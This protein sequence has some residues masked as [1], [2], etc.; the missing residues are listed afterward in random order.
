MSLELL[1]KCAA[2]GSALTLVLATLGCAGAK[3][4]AASSAPGS[5]PAGNPKAVRVE[6]NPFLGQE[7]FVAPY[8]NADQARRRL[9]N[10]DPA[11]AALVAKIADTPQARWLGSW[12]Q[13]VEVVAQNYVKAASKRNKLALIIAYNIPNRDCGQYSRGG[14]ADPQAYLKWV[15]ELAQGIGDSRAVV[16]LEPDALPQLD[17]CLSEADQAQRL[18]LL[19]SAVDILQAKPG[20]AVYLDAGHSAWVPAQVMAERLKRAGVEK[21]RGFAL[22]TSNYRLDAEL[23]TYGDALVSK[24]GD[25]HFII[26]SSRNGNGAAAGDNWCNP[27]GRALGRRPT[28]ETGNPHLDAF[29]WLK[30]PGESDGECGGGPAAGQWF[31]ERAFEMARN[32]KW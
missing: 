28:T 15:Q 20:V 24:L 21:A 12:T 13:N 5:E 3:Q 29:M 1:C 8:S 7:V 4:G 23:I 9:A 17:M 30:A 10:S 22:N 11:A 2:K 19:Q 6:G 25:T 16:V 31:S 26:D 27:E 32:A 14:A 18:E